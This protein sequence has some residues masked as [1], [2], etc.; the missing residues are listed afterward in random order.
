MMKVEDNAHVH[1]SKEWVIMPSSPYRRL[2]DLVLVM[3]LLFY[4]FSVPF[5]IGFLQSF[6]GVHEKNIYGN[7]VVI[8]I[9]CLL[10]LAVNMMCKA[11]IFAAV[12][13][14]VVLKEQKKITAG[15][16][17]LGCL[18]DMIRFMN[19]FPRLVDNRFKGVANTL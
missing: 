6:T 11:R 14:G 13:N 19:I 3:V 17:G 5:K 10:L 1:I 16:F 8:D 4:C 9:I 18:L 15:T 7:L 2:W 12:Q